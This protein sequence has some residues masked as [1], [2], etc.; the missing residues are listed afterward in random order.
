MQSTSS[1][2]RARGRGLIFI[3]LIAAGLTLSPA[4]GRAAE[5]GPG[6][7]PVSLTV[8]YGDLN[9]H[10]SQGLLQL[11]LRIVTAANQACGGE[12][13]GRVPLKEWSRFRA[14]TVQSINRAV[15]VIGNPD[16]AM[17][18]ARRT[19]RPIGT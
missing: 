9:L 17:L 13:R 15:N 8:Q 19:G 14:C 12:T 10:S 2:A 18:L 4:P 11:S 6:E 1:L 3:T 5:P 16:L 7:Q